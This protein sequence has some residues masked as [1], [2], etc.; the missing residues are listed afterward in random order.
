MCIFLFG[1]GCIVFGGYQGGMVQENVVCFLHF[2]VLLSSE[3]YVFM[4]ISLAW[5]DFGYHKILEA[6]KLV[7]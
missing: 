7:S 2:D 5:V 1:I 4:Y 3:V 6:N